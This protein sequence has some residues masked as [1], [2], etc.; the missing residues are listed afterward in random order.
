MK[1]PDLALSR[2]DSFA[3]I[4]QNEYAILCLKDLDGRPYGLPM[5]YVRQGEFLYFHGSREGRKIDSMRSCQQACAVITGQTEIVPHKFGRT[6][7]SVIIDGTIELVDDPE[8]KRQAMSLV[9]KRKSPDYVE[10]G[11]AIIEKLL[12]R[13]LVYKMK[14]EFVSGKRGL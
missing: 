6:Y 4:D 12:D 2:E 13:V 14:M 8:L 11:Y 5:D 1:R 9:V 7:K 10:K 3:L